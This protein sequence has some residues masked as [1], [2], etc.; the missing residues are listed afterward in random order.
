MPKIDLARIRRRQMETYTR[1]KEMTKPN[2]DGGYDEEKVCENLI[3]ILPFDVEKAR[4][5][6]AQ[7]LINS[8]T[9]PGGTNPNGQITLPGLDVFDYE[10]NR[11]IRD[12]SGNIYEWGTSPLHAIMAEANRAREHASA[13]NYWSNIKAV[14]VEVFTA[15][16]VD[17]MEKGRERKDLT[18]GNCIKEAGFWRPDAAASVS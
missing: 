9:R 18:W 3:K 6:Q 11:L 13:A 16:V 4:R 1:A 5:K 12:G 14:E 8:L 10:P 2:E 17:Q 15:W 7:L